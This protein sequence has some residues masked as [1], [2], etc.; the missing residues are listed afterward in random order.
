MN[1][2]RYL[3]NLHNYSKGIDLPQGW[4]RTS[5]FWLI[6]NNEVVGVVRI[7]HEEKK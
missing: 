5:T 2:L 4:V 1:E 3:N 7:R 6:D